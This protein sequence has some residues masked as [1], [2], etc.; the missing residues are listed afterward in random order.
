[1]KRT[2]TCDV[3]RCEAKNYARGG[4]FARLCKRHYSQVERHGRLT[5]E[6]ERGV[7]RVCLVE[8]CERTDTIGQYCRKHARQVRVHGR[9][10]PEREHEFGRVGCTVPGCSEEHRA[11]GYCVRHYNQMRWQRIKRLIARAR[12]AGLEA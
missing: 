11:Q 4:G 8:G 12:E 3:P 2:W 9:L 7:V 6:R 5:P 10:T 1:M